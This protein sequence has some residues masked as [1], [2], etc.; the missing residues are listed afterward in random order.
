VTRGRVIKTV[1]LDLDGTLSDSKP[2]IAGCFRHVL[3]TLGHDADAAGDLSWAVGPPIAT[4]LK[5]L[6]APYGDDRVAEALALYRARYSAVAIYECAVY[7]GVRAM[8]E[9]LRAHAIPMHICTSKRRDFAEVVM[10]HLGLRDFVGAVYGA[11]PEGG[12][13][14]KY[15]LLAHLLTQERLD[16]D[17]TALLGD[18]LHDVH[19][20]KAN[21]VRSIGALWGY[22]GAEELR[23]A[24]ADYLAAAPA[25]VAE[26]LC[27]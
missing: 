20:A 1:L 6:L 3:T 11:L 23:Q 22:G 14:E 2:G 5:G 25:E 19:A 7:P 9:T 24:G 12:L 18:R 16:P 13:E 4:S 27:L 21:G 17:A 26:L 10:T 8:L 15:D